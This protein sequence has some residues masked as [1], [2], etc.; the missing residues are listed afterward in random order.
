MAKRGETRPFRMTF[1]W[2][3]S[4]ITG[5]STFINL[6][7]AEFAARQQAERSGPAGLADCVATVTHRDSPTDALFIFR[8]PDA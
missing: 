1:K 8:G 5:T 6:D 7:G 4:G 3:G 2:E